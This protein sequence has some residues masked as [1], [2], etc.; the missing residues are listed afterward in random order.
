MQNTN[1]FYLPE[2][3]NNYISYNKKKLLIPAA[4]QCKIFLSYGLL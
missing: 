2:D 3:L 1:M 4:I